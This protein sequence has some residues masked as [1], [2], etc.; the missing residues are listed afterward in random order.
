MFE[1]HVFEKNIRVKKFFELDRLI[2]FVVVKNYCNWFTNQ[3]KNNFHGVPQGSV[4]GPVS[5]KIFKIDFT[6]INDDTSEKKVYELICYMEHKNIQ[7][8]G[9]ETLKEL[10]ST[11]ST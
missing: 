11:L 7:Q 1:E 4:L 10:S 5:F 9:Q 8:Q 3:I 2:R 6:Y